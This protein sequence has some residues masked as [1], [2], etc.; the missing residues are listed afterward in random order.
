MVHNLKLHQFRNYTFFLKSSN[1]TFLKTLLI[2]NIIY[3]TKLSY[4]FNNKNSL[5]QE[6]FT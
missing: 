2:A 4:Y 3:L 6:V 5:N 1:F